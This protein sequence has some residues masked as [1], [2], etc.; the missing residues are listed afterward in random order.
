[1]ISIPADNYST[2]LLTFFIFKIGTG[3]FNSRG[4]DHE[5]TLGGALFLSV[6]RKLLK[7][8]KRTVNIRYLVA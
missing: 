7:R 3:F 6:L 1:M 4:E 5:V 8:R 2:N